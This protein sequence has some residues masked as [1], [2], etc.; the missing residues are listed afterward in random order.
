MQTHTT[1]NQHLTRAARDH[2]QDEDL[3]AVLRELA[4]AVKMI[5]AAVSRGGLATDLRG[6]TGGQNVHGEEVQKL[7][8]YANDL[9]VAVL[10][11]C[12]SVALMASEESEEPIPGLPGGR[13][14]VAFDPLDGSS[15]I[16]TN[17]SIGTI[18]SIHAVAEGRSP[19]E[20][21]AQ[22]LLRPGT[23]QVA[24]GYAIYGS[25]TLFVY[26]AR[27]GVYGFT[28]DLTLGELLLS[29][30]GIACPATGRTY[31][32]NEGNAGYWSQAQ[33]DLVAWYK[34]PDSATRRPYKARYIGSLV[35][36]FHRTLV[37]GGIFLYPA[38]EKNPRGKLRYL[39]EAAPL[40]LVCEE[41]GGASTDGEVRMLERVPQDLHERA[42]LFIGSRELVEAATRRLGGA[43]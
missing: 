33:S 17:A 7:D 27:H 41:A 32:V 24:A 10:G 42:P 16:D 9:L 25:S 19:S 39:Y 1:L 28:L 29:H 15:N 36:D 5:A 2:G 12:D 18:F 31:S 6:L 26:T 8:L 21:G 23:E 38:D 37:K 40:S 34:T 11:R 35:A 14:S 22:D 4:A 43:G 13:Y 3:N 20:L 30:D